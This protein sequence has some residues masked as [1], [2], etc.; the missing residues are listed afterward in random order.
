M[1]RA[2]ETETPATP[3]PSAPAS[4]FSHPALTQ[5]WPHSDDES[6]HFI[7]VWKMPSRGTGNGSSQ[8]QACMAGSRPPLYPQSSPQC[9]GASGLSGIILLLLT[10]SWKLCGSWLRDGSWTSFMELESEV[11]WMGEHYSF[12]KCVEHEVPL[13]LCLSVTDPSRGPRNRGKVLIPWFQ[14]KYKSLRN[15][16]ESEPETSNKKA[17]AVGRAV[18]IRAQLPPL[19]HL[20]LSAAELNLL[21]LK[22]MKTAV[23]KLKSESLHPAPLVT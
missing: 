12:Y 8:H 20:C 9:P 10:P 6:Y 7:S 5:S 15:V 14:V 18:A 23:Q 13:E 11:A 3:H 17:K 16:T 2:K 21:L 19:C 1:P 4:F 22:T